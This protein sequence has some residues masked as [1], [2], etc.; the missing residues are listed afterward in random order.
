MKL[1]PFTL[2]LQLIQAHFVAFNLRKPRGREA[3]IKKTLDLPIER[4]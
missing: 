3:I 1:S 4:L 2:S